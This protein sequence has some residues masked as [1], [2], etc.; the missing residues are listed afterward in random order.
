MVR[1]AGQAGPSGAGRR[2]GGAGDVGGALLRSRFVPF[3]HPLVRL[4]VLCFLFC[5]LPLSS[6][7]H[8]ALVPGARCRRPCLMP[9][10]SATVLMGHGRGDFVV[11]AAASTCT[12][13]A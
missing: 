3:H 2:L 8:H 1:A 11:L 10:D 12:L 5:A 13:G 9:I 7:R 6:P 4:P